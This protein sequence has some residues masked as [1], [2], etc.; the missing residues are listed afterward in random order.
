MR[1]ADEDEAKKLNAAPWQVELLALNPSY[2]GWGPHED[3]MWTKDSEGWN[4]CQLFD[5]WS[6]FGPWHL[7]E[8]NEC[9]NFYFSVERASED[10]KTCGGNG[11]HPDAQWVGQSWYSHSSPFK[12][13]TLGELQAE[14]VMARFGCCRAPPT[15]AGSSK[16]S[17]DRPS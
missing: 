11:E 8:L 2:L 12:H 1:Y 4:S 10:C 7:D 13:K 3:Y 5:S 16:A 15:C 6:A 9:V 17:T 14:A